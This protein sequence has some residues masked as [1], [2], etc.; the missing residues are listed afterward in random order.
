MTHKWKAMKHR[1]AHAEVGKNAL[2][3][4]TGKSNMHYIWYGRASGASGIGN[5]TTTNSLQNRLTTSFS[6]AMK[7]SKR[8]N[9]EPYH[10]AF[11][12]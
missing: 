2:V 6:A 4:Q 12:L 3:A 5:A 7:A 11:E 10:V 1:E 8:M 9:L